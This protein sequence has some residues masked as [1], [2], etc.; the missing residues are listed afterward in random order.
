MSKLLSRD[1]ILKASELPTEIVEVPEWGGS[2]QVRGLNGRQ[3]DTFQIA[4]IGKDGKA[5]MG[6]MNNMR[7]SLVSRTV[8]N[9]KGELMFGPDDVQALGE[10]SGAALDRVFEVA[11]RLSGM[12]AEVMEEQINVFTS[13]QNGDSVSA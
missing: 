4:M 11:Q 3:L 5:D 2:V 1:E 9:D 6:R 8:V 13:A 10:L 7:A 12:K